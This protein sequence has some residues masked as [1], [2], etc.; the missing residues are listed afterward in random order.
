[1]Q[2]SMHKTSTE[3]YAHQSCNWFNQFLHMKKTFKLQIIQT[4]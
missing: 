2:L 3:A 1:M 4:D